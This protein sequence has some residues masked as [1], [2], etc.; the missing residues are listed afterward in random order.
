MPELPEVEVLVRHLDP[1]VRGR[2]VLGVKV[3]RERVLRPSLPPEFERRLV[4]ARFKG[5]SRRGKY[6][7]FE[8]DSRQAGQGVAVL[9][10]L[11]MTGRMYLAPV[12]KPLPKH[13]AVVLNLGLDNFVFEDARGFGRLTLCLAALDRLGPEP[14]GKGFTVRG[15]AGAL[16][17]S[18]RPVKVKLLDQSVL[19]GVGNIYASE[20]LFRA[21]I[22][23]LCAA[24]LLSADQAEC[25]WRM[26]RRT[27]RDAIR[28]GSG[29]PLDFGGG[30]V[31]GGGLFYFGVEAG[32]LDFYT[33]RLQVYGRG[34]LPCCRCGGSIRREVV[35]G[36]STFFCPC[37]QPLPKLR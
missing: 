22:S 35:G 18:S 24:R 36:R 2:E 26:I 21:G 6:L 11:G 27:L 19:A 34:G 14:L 31:G 10:H 12:S 8:L 1:L 37:C 23:P 9:G 7:F 30:G 5:L 15:F 17:G 4:G 33:E 3:L 20:A 32:T 16:Q 28:C 13:A 29:I 25:L